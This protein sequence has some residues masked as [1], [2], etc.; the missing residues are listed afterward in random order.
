M[1]EMFEIRSCTCTEILSNDI[2]IYAKKTDG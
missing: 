2:K 1:E